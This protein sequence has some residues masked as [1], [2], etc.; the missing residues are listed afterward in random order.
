MFPDLFLMPRIDL[1]FVTGPY[2]EETAVLGA[3]IL[4]DGPERSPD[5]VG[6]ETCT[7]CDFRLHQIVQRPRDPEVLDGDGLECA[8]GST[9]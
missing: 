9:N 5:R 7:R 6:I 2:L 3:E 4:D 1:L 8:H